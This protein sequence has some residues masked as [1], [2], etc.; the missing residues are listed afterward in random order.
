MIKRPNKKPEVVRF[1]SHI[2]EAIHYYKATPYDELFYRGSLSA[3]ILV[4]CDAPTDVAYG[5]SLT[6]GTSQLD[7]FWKVA[8]DKGI[9]ED[10]VCFVTPCPPMPPEAEGS[11]KREGEFLESFRPSFL[12]LLKK[13]KAKVYIHLGVTA[14]RQLIGKSVAITKVRGQVREYDNLS[15]PVIAMLSPGQVL[16]QPGY[17]EQFGVDFD[18]LVRLRSYGYSAAKAGAMSKTLNYRWATPEQIRQEYERRAREGPVPIVLDTETVGGSWWAGAT[19]IIAQIS[20]EPGQ[21]FAFPVNVEYCQKIQKKSVTGNTVFK[22]LAKD[23]V[24]RGMDFLHYL[25]EEAEEAYFSGQNLK[26]DLHILRN[27]GV[28]LRLDRWIHDS[29]QLSFAA[30]EN[31]ISK[32][33]ANLTRL[34][35][36]EMGGYSDEFDRTVDKSDMMAVDPDFMLPYAC[37]DVDAVSRITPRLLDIVS[38]DE[39]QLNCYEK[40]Q[41]PSLRMFVDV[42]RRGITID[43]D[44]LVDFGKELATET[45]ELYAE[46]IAQVAPSIRDK[47]FGKKGEDLRFSRAKFV[48]DIMF[49]HKDGFRFKPV[50]WTDGTAHLEMKDRVP[51]V[52]AGS[53]FPYFEDEPWV[54]QLMRYQELQKMQSTYVGAEFDEEKQCATGIWQ[55]IGEDNKIHPSYWL[56]RTVTG[57]TASSDPN[58][59]NF[60]KRGDLAKAFRRIFRA[61]KG[62]V[63]IEADLSQAELRGAAW[64][65]ME[66]TMLRLYKEGVDI[67]S[68]TAAA[69]M[70]LTLKAFMDLPEDQIDL[71]RQRAK[72]VNFGFIYGMW[73]KRFRSYAKTDYGLDLTEAESEAMRNK[74]FALYPKLENW[75]DDARR[76]VNRNGFVRAKHGA[77]RSLYDIR[78]VDK[79]IRMMAERQA[80]NS[81]VQRMA[82]DTALM[83]AIRFHADCPKHVGGLV[84]FI[85][86]SGIAEV[87]IAHKDIAAAALK[88]YM[89]TPPYKKWFGI[90]CPVPVVSDVAWGHSLDDMHKMKT[91]IAKPARWSRS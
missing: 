5:S 70:D 25:A 12:S 34:F 62:Y 40:I 24:K 21:G 48:I 16:R 10:E 79:G 63:F 81:P 53:H 59:Q 49:A 45:E 77:K 87:K 72:A 41:M 75:H 67:H 52:S 47:H 33:L 66:P 37:G 8:A 4:V 74:F 23:V 84:A 68:A 64:N 86:D 88:H 38:M 83:G 57:R 65:A 69:V 82:S 39:G 6:M 31:I 60:P 76:E 71:Y 36:P 2:K 78:S 19:A 14:G 3:P 44:A 50:V 89:E 13:S 54:A 7:L 28:N 17:R 11:A 18:M 1:N 43:K 80:I 26:Y 29:M 91:L 27:M 56:H 22:G 85:H 35:A 32:D 9:T 73:W 20:F 55:Y 61:S 90:E 58:G 51:S 42:E 30:N 15:A 46:L